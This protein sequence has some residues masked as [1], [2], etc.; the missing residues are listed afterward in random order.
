MHASVPEALPF[1][2]VLGDAPPAG[3]DE[4]AVVPGLGAAGLGAVVA[5]LGLGFGLGGAVVGAGAL[6][7]VGAG[8]AMP[9]CCPEPNRKPTTEPG[10]GS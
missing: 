8:G 10:A 5:G 9:G 6:V 7:F 4:V 3:V 1:A 2:A